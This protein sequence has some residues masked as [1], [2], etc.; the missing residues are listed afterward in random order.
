MQ[1]ESNIRGI[2]FCGDWTKL[3]DDWSVEFPSAASGMCRIGA[4]KKRGP[5]GKR[6]K[7]QSAASEYENDFSSDSWKNVFWWRGGK[8][9]K[10][11]LQKGLPSSLVKKAGRQGKDRVS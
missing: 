6:Y 11:L 4:S 9:L 1:L 3:V 7:K 2:A 5:G 10:V 8:L